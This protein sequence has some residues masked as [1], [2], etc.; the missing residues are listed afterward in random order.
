[1]TTSF[2]AN[3]GSVAERLSKIRDEIVR[4]LEADGEPKQAFRRPRGGAL[5]GGAVLHEALGPAQTRSAGE[6]PQAR[7]DV[8]CPSAAPGHD[9]RQ[10]PAGG[11]HLSLRDGVARV[12]AK[13]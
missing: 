13:P 4:V 2:A 1:M 5:H 6:E 8:E 12:R 10:H 11:R 3:Y 9:E 7:R